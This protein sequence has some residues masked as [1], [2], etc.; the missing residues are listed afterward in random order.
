MQNSECRMQPEAEPL[1]TSSGRSEK[2]RLVELLRE[3]SKIFTDKAREETFRCLEEK[4]H[5]DSRTD[6]TVDYY[7]EIADHLLENSV[8]VPPYKAGTKV[9][10]ISSY[11]I[12]DERPYIIE[13]TI[14][15]YYYTKN[16]KTIVLK[17]HP[18]V[19]YKDWDKVFLSHE[20]AK[21]WLKNRLP[22]KVSDKIMKHFTEVE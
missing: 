20:D 5:F 10:V 1:G 22:S 6:R 19:W 21:K 12:D 15:H 3:G 2:E 11:F 16:I 9:Y 17:N 14:S 18:P 4:H 13:D 7:E 8:I